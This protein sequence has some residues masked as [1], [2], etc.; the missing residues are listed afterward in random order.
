MKKPFLISLILTGTMLSAQTKA[1]DL[2]YDF[3]TFY[4]CLDSATYRNLFTDTYIKDSL[5][6]C[7]EASTH[8]GEEDYSGKYAIGQTATLEFFS[9]AMT[10]Q[11]GDHFGDAGLEFKTRRYGSLSEYAANAKKQQI[12]FNR[13]TTTIPGKKGMLKWYCSLICEKRPDPLS[14]IMLEYQPEY[15]RLLGFSAAETKIAMSPLA[16]NTRLSKGKKFPRLFSS[17][18]SVTIVVSPAERQLLRDFTDMYGFTL[19]DTELTGGPFSIHYS[20]SERAPAFRVQQ[21]AIALLKATA[22]RDITVSPNLHVITKGKTATLQFH[23]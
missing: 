2:K 23:Y 21:V 13:D 15:M 11:H 18:T 7:K 20:I 16:F 4:V 9:P 6:F 22:A 17:I 1:P 8:T 12:P 3:N 5:F 14:L 19:T 10:D